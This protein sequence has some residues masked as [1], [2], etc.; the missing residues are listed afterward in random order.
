METFDIILDSD[1]ELIPEN[2]DFK[3]GD[4]ANNLISY[5]VQANK[6]EY[7]EFPEIGVGIET[8][9]NG[10]KNIQEI[11]RDIINELK[12]DVFPDPDVDMDD[13]PSIIRIN[14]V[15]FELNS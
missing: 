5:L 6:G 12:A 2:G 3:T 10:I 14:K 15:S 11:E 4:N 9:L 7:K 8:Y 1:G 13:Y